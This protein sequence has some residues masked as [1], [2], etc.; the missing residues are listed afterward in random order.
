MFIGFDYRKVLSP[1]RGRGRQLL[2]F[3]SS[4]PRIIQTTQRHRKVVILD[5]GLVQITFSNP[6]GD[7]IGIKY[8]KIKNLLETHNKYSNRGYW[9]IEWGEGTTSGK[10]N[11]YD[12]IEGR[13]F[14]IIK[15]DENQIE[16][17][18]VKKWNDSSHIF[19]VNMDK[20]Y[21]M[22]RDYPGFYTYG[23]LDHPKEA[24]ATQ[25]SVVRA[26]FKLQGKKFNYMAISDDRQR[27]MPSALDRIKGQKLA[28]AEAVLLTRPTNPDLKGEVDDK[29]QYSSD[30]KDI[31]VHGWISSNPSVGFWII[32]PSQEFLTA[33][34]MKQELTSHVGPTSLSVFLSCHYV[35]KDLMVKLEKGETWRKVFGPIS[36]YLNS[37]SNNP[38]PHSLLWDNAKS[39]AEEEVAKWPY[40]FID[41]K[42]YPLSNQ[43]GS[44]TGQLYVFDRFLNKNKIKAQFAYVGLAAPGKVGSWQW[45][46]KGYQFW[47]QADKKGNFIIKNVRPGNY[48]LYAWAPGVIG[49]YVYNKTITIEPGSKINLNNLVYVPPRNGPTLWEIG[50]PDR[51]ASEFY[52]P[53]PLT[54]VTNRLFTNKE[55][56]RFRQYGLWDRYTDLYPDKDLI[57]TIGVND[58]RKDW[59]FA[60]VNRKLQNG[61]YQQ[62]TWQVKFI[63]EEVM[64]SRD[65]TLQLALASASTSDLQV[66]FNELNTYRPIFSTHLLGRDN[67]I[68]RHG[69][70]GTYWIYSI[71]IS[72]NWLRQ[73]ENILYLTQSRS[74]GPFGGILYDYLRFEAP[75]QTQ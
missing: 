8:N 57:Y 63:L 4:T 71:S 10:A 52:V 41:S 7:V 61:T 74:L 25:I 17:S 50:I 46:N 31:R 59:F 14:E 42:D 37:V 68:A 75:S 3:S 67:S 53:D 51:T 6:G 30:H 27:T 55:K 5:N 58:Y 38:N 26:A 2:T 18:F 43:R 47:S 45:E 40:S 70:H 29:Y 1:I 39:Q 64:W 22:L 16:I 24:P 49:D 20:R 19:P 69:I 48:N 35:G 66:R 32:T 36:I 60:H 28:Y 12:K 23:I 54:N 33:G 13:H 62:T 73:G 11:N 9:D 44:V 21:I 65:Y 72:S 15:A 56:H 34:P